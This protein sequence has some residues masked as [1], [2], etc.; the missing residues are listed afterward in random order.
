MLS[1]ML[2]VMCGMILGSAIM[3][4]VIVCTITSKRGLKWYAKKCTELAIKIG[5][6]AKEISEEEE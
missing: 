5:E 3:T 6:V 4:T 1:T 2:G